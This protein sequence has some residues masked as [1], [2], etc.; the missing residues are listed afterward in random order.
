MFLIRVSSSDILDTKRESN[1]T[2]FNPKLRKLPEVSIM[3]NTY[4]RYDL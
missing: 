2:L 3:T 1:N 4:D